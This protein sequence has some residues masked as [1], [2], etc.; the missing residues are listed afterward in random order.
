MVVLNN[1]SLNP[2]PFPQTFFTWVLLIGLVLI[3]QPAGSA[4]FVPANIEMATQEPTGIG[5]KP[6]Q[7]KKRMKWWKGWWSKLK[8][9]FHKQESQWNDITPRVIINLLLSALIHLLA[10]GGISLG[11]LLFFGP[12]LAIV[13][14]LTSILLSSVIGIDLFGKTR[15]QQKPRL[16][17]VVSLLISLFSLVFLHWA[18]GIPGMLLMG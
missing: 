10:S 6:A 12:G 2:N 1:R 7:Q 13:G 3:A 11:F 4:V 15:L 5:T 9:P 18:T 8:K 16:K 14:Y 17:F